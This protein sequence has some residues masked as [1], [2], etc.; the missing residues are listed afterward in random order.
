MQ[1]VLRQRDLERQLLQL[2]ERV[3]GRRFPVI[4][5]EHLG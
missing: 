1:S 2:A 4:Q 5:W 3:R